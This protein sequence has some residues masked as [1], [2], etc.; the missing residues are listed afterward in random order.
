[1]KSFG[2][3]SVRLPNSAHAADPNARLKVSKSGNICAG[4]LGRLM[5]SR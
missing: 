1:M 3:R 4:A 2:R 5:R